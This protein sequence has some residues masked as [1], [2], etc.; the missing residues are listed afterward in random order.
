M[1]RKWSE[2]EKELLEHLYPSEDKDSILKQLSDRSWSAICNMARKIG[3]KRVDWH[4]ENSKGKVEFLCEYCGDS[5]ER[6]HNPN[7]SDRFCSQE[8]YYQWQREHPEENYFYKNPMFGSAN[9]NWGR[10][11]NHRKNLDMRKLSLLGRLAQRPQKLTRPEKKLYEILNSY[12][13]EFE[14]QKYIGSYCVDAFIKP[15]IIIEVDGEYWHNYPYGKET[16]A[17]RD[18]E[19][20]EKGY[21]VHRYWAKDILNSGQEELKWL[22]ACFG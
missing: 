22:F 17:K 13:I 15:N 12:N 10:H 9:G 2:N 16:D 19:L 8:C 6:F 18:K 21:K 7:N 11:P 14:P 1:G 3:V 5:V 20:Q 4:W